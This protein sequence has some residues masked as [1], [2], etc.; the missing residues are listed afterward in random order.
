MSKVEIFKDK[1]LEDIFDKDESVIKMALPAPYTSSD[2][3]KL[4]G[5]GASSKVGFLYNGFP[6]FFDRTTFHVRKEDKKIVNDLISSLK[7]NLN[8]SV[9]LFER[10]K[11]IRKS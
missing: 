4:L 3:V 5:K 8:E 7:S 2:V 9:S 6:I 11:K 1:K 10:I